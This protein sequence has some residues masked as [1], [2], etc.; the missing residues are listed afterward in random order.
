MEQENQTQEQPKAQELTMEQFAA[1]Q[2]KIMIEQN[3]ILKKQAAMI[4][5][6]AIALEKFESEFIK[7]TDYNGTTISCSIYSDEDI[8][9]A[10]EV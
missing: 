7:V 8:E 3:E 6:V 5:R 9:D 1:F 2:A 10:E 4:E